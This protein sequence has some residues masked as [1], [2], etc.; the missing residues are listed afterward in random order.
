[1]PRTLTA[2]LTSACGRIC[3]QQSL[4]LLP[5]VLTLN[6]AKAAVFDEA[7]FIEDDQTIAECT[8]ANIFI[9]KGGR[10]ATPPKSH[11]ILGGV[12]RDR[13]I[14]LARQ[15][16]VPLEERPVTLPELRAA[17]EVF[18]TSTTIVVLPAT[19]VDQQPVGAGKSGPVTENLGELFRAA[20]A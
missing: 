19:Q 4:C 6:R 20:V 2:R 12:T 3:L 10:V 13:V 7:V 14:T 18:L 11:P 5:N 9:I 16:G 1:M 8:A 15:H 17:D